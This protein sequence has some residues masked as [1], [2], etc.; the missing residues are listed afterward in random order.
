MPLCRA[1][2]SVWFVSW[3]WLA[4]WARMSWL[5]AF[6]HWKFDSLT[7][8]NKEVMTLSRLVLTDDVAHL[9]ISRKQF[10]MVQTLL[11]QICWSS[12]CS[13]RS[14]KKKILNHLLNHFLVPL[15]YRRQKGLLQ[16]ICSTI[17]RMTKKKLWQKQ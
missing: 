16:L 8:E 3:L 4:H 6:M 5:I 12:K 1:T 15:T 10:C 9:K 13:R 11:W 14:A 17:W 7:Y 2:Y